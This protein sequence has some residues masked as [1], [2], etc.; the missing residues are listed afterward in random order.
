MIKSIEYLL[1]FLNFQLTNGPLWKKF[2]CQFFI[3]TTIDCGYVWNA[4]ISFVFNVIIN[5]WML[6]CTIM[7]DIRVCCDDT[8]WYRIHFEWLSA[9]QISS[10][11]YSF[12]IFSYFFYLLGSFDEK[13]HK[14]VVHTIQNEIGW[15]NTKHKQHQKSK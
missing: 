11:F 12:I 13:Q 14:Y 1:S 7:A 5:S 3:F 6:N 15:V 9:R 2:I 10:W 4:D 8:K